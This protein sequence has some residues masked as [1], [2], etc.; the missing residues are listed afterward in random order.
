[1]NVLVNGI[2]NIGT[3]VISLLANYRKE[4]NIDTIYALKNNLTPWLECDLESIK[5]L[6]IEICTRTR[7]KGYLEVGSIMEKVNFVFDC[8]NNGG[9]LRN[10]SWY[11]SFPNLIG[12]CAQGSEK[13]FGISFMSGVNNQIITNERY[14]HIV[15]CNTHSIASLLQ[16]FAGDKLENLDSSDFVIVRRSE[17]IGNHERLVSANVVARHLDPHLGTHHSIDVL[18]LYKTLGLVF[19]VTSSDVTTPSQ[20]MHGVRFHITLKQQPDQS[21]IENSILNSSFVAFSKKFDSNIIF[22]RGRR[23]GHQGRIYNHAIILSNNIMIIDRSLVGWAFI[24]QEGNTLISTLNAYLLQTGHPETIKV[25]Q[26]IKS[27]LLR[28]EW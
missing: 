2:G 18:D 10:K 5:E 3:T 6:G 11:D 23:W 7:E 8:T 16:T 19:P 9:G 22:E 4:L 20:L 17:D 21:Y 28:K 14:V 27:N 13:G 25:I 15:S 24:P 1:M 26:Q 12:A